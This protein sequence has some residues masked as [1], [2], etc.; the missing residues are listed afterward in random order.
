MVA[1]PPVATTVNM[2]SPSPIWLTW[3]GMDSLRRGQRRLLDLL[4]TVS[5]QC[6]Y[7]VVLR[8]PEMDLRA[9]R[10]NEGSGPVL[11]IVPAPIKRSYIWDLAPWAS[12]VGE[13]LRAGIRVFLID[14]KESRGKPSTAGL[15]DYADEF[16]DESLRAIE[17][18]TGIHEVFLTGHSLGGT[19][20]AIFA[21]LHPFSIRGLI[22]VGAPINLGENAGDLAPM[23]LA[24]PRAHE[25]TAR[26]GDVPGSFMSVMSSVASPSTFVWE[27]W[28]DL[29]AASKDERERETH[30]LV[31]R[32][33]LDEL[34]MPRDLFRDVVELLYRE[35]RFMS[36][37]L[38]VSGRRALPRKVRAPI[39]SVVDPRCR[40]VPPESVLPFHDVVGSTDT[41]VLHY[42]GDTGVAVQHLGL[43]VGR[44][45][46]R[47]IWPRI[48]NWIHDRARG[49]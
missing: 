25:L 7:R 38:E 19:L 3:S 20:S 45:A 8:K 12:V 46:H 26:W 39:L 49:S 18:E 10:E 23:V 35:N 24:S 14:W 30:L 44:N 43:L 13:A 34:P 29:I 33:M 48:M 22:L 41:Q 37:D 36:G 32:W 5:D 15:A 47:D 31:T 42:R 1:D 4:G 28:T 40:I 2:L 27:R 11:L 16:I 21:S 17:E 6:P 9:Y